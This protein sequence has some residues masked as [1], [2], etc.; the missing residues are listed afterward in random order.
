LEANKGGGGMGGDFL[1]VC[2]REKKKNNREKVKVR[3]K[4]EKGEKRNS[5]QEKS[6]QEKSATRQA[7]KD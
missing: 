5:D 4:L 2:F 7:S 3:I 1:C 6:V